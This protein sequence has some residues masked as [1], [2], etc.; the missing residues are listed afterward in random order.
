MPAARAHFPQF[1][2]GGKVGT[3]V[4]C[5]LWAGALNA[6]L[7][8]PPP[9]GTDLPVPPYPRMLAGY[10]ITRGYKINLSFLIFG[11][12]NVNT[13]WTFQLIMSV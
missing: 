10:F 13:L 1:G 9:L 6:G 5:S 11:G 12:T 8:L 3:V 7:W 2:G 4:S